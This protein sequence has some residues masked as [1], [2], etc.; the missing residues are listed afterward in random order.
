M[1]SH[2]KVLDRLKI[3]L[4]E[5]SE[6]EF[7]TLLQTLRAHNSKFGESNKYI[8]QLIQ[9]KNSSIHFDKVSDAQ[10]KSLERLEIKILENSSFE[11]NLERESYSSFGRTRIRI[12]KYFLFAEISIEKGSNQ[13][14]VYFLQKALK[15]GRRIE[16]YDSVVYALE[17]L[18][19]CYSSQVNLESMLKTSRELET[20]KKELS[21]YNNANDLLERIRFNSHRE[22]DF[23]SISDEDKIRVY[24]DY[25]STRSIRTKRLLLYCKI[26]LLEM[27]DPSLSQAHTKR[28]L[29]TM[30]NLLSDLSKRSPQLFPKR[31][32]LIIDLN[33]N[34]LSV[35]FGKI[36]ETYSYLQRVKSEFRKY[37]HYYTILIR[38]CERV[39]LFTSRS[40]L[41]F[42]QNYVIEKVGHVDSFNSAIKRLISGK[43]VIKVL[44]DGFH[45]IDG[46]N[47]SFYVKAYQILSAL[48]KS[49]VDLAFHF[50]DGMR[51]LCKSHSVSDNSSYSRTVKMFESWSKKGFQGQI[52]DLPK[53]LVD[54]IKEH[55]ENTWNPLSA[56]VIPLHL[57]NNPKGLPNHKEVY[58]H[59]FE[60]KRNKSIEQ[61]FDLD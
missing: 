3:I 7:E 22:S 56:D 49:D 20:A 30:L 36:E 39:N 27:N 5:T 45:N 29:S 59:L 11:F 19:K 18:S 61:G 44:V 28:E 54:P 33:K 31:E 10:R 13:L 55:Y 35:Y 57:W 4:R 6:R 21:L 60:L 37:P 52:Q 34:I 16:Q 48:I 17:K 41:N 15:A 50:F 32:D 1:K 26:G 38:Y 46:L 8:E 43:S 14:C 2:N 12:S 25:K 40:D 9:L 23:F 51:Y 47:K 58:A 42:S 24:A 53:E